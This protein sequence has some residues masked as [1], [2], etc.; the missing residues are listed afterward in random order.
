MEK[1]AEIQISY[2]ELKAYVKGELIPF[3]Y[4]IICFLVTKQSII[5]PPP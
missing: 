3:Y 4:D 1:Q 2:V 5:F